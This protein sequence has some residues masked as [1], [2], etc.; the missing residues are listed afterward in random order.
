M[1]ISIPSPDSAALLLLAS[2]FPSSIHAKATTAT[3]STLHACSDIATA[4]PGRVSYPGS[5]AYIKETNNYWSGALKQ[6][7]PACLVLPTSAGEV[8]SVVKVLNKFPDVDFAVKSG[9]H[10]PNPGHAS[11]ND[12]ILIATAEMSGA[13]YDPETSLAS[14]GPGGVWNDVIGDLE[15]YGVTVAGGRL[16]KPYL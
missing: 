11:V 13:T 10:D 15:P 1:K 2:M 12:G 4:L 14:V 3:P 16:G 8:S 5:L 7:K 9:G 6:M